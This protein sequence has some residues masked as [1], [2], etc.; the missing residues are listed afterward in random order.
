[1]GGLS[2]WHLAIV[3][4][5]IFILFGKGKFSGLMEDLAKGVKTL[6]NGLSDEEKL[7]PPSV[8]EVHH[9]HDRE[10]APDE[11]DRS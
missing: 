9:Y 8:K 5:V 11:I 7:P 3:A 10:Q 1:M 4:G 6:K 2:I